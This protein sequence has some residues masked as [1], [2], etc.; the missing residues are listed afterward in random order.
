MTVQ[1]E[2]ELRQNIL[3]LT[4]FIV[5]SHHS[6]R[7]YNIWNLSGIVP[8]WTASSV[9]SIESQLLSMFW[10][11]RLAEGQVCSALSTITRSFAAEPSR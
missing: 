2:E 11:I 3:V 5:W 8:S 1:R 7:P 9:S 10:R 4:N 6:T